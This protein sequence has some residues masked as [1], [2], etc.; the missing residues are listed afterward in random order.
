MNIYVLL[1]SDG[2][3]AVVGSSNG[4]PV[5]AAEGGGA[6]GGGGG[7]AGARADADAEHASSRCKLGVLVQHALPRLAQRLGAY[8]QVG[9]DWVT[10]QTDDRGAPLPDTVASLGSVQ[11]EQ[12]WLQL[13]Q[14]VYR[15]L[16]CTS[17]CMP[18]TCCCLPSSPL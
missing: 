18:C 6:G 7:E 11:D 12:H 3:T 14:L 17:R 16:P 9:L 1:A 15:C 5:G 13:R 4:A 8:G 2:S 10:W